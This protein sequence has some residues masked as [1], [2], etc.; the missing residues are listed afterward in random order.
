MGGKRSGKRDYFF[1]FITGLI[2]YSLF[3]CALVKEKPVVVEKEYCSHL[4]V[5]ESLERHED[6]DTF[7]KQKL[8]MLTA[9]PKNR[10]ADDL[11]Y[12]LGLLY[13]HPANPGKNYKKSL[14]FFRRVINEYPR[15]ACV[16]EAKIWAGVLE[17][18]EKAAKVDIEIE[19]KKKEL[20]K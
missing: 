5:L 3:S 17:D 18:I 1:L 13:A 19:Q 14:A 4:Q 7:L 10:S 16:R 15:S 9:L 6:F 8:D 20:G 2:F 12:V 11:L